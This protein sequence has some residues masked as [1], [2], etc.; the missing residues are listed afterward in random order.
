MN[1]DL[2]DIKK[3]IDQY[4]DGD[5]TIEEQDRLAEF[6]RSSDIPEE[7]KPYQAMFDLLAVPMAEPSDEEVDAF[8]LANG[9]KIKEKARVV[10]MIL[11]VASVVAVI[12]VV[13][14]I[15]YHLGC[16]GGMN[17]ASPLVSAPLVKERIIRQVSVMKDTVMI[18]RPIVVKKMIVKKVATN[19]CQQ[20]GEKEMIAR[21]ISFVQPDV[22]A[23]PI[24][25][26]SSMV[27]TSPDD[28]NKYFNEVLE[29]NQEI[30]KKE[31]KNDFKS[32]GYEV[33]F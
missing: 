11:K 16:S 26:V 15:G 17:T 6:F 9:V 21:D 13:F 4:L 1:K 19:E 28:V 18:E 14:V 12:L 3:L 20:R 31:V 10:P 22:I 7:L 2:D 8:A 32:Y 33:S 27:A 5:A 24:H 30:E 29:A 25:Q 23:P